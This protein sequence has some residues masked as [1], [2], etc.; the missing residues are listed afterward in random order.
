MTTAIDFSAVKAKQQKT[1]SSGDY[2]AVAARI[3]PISEQLI[4][5]AD[6]PA[7]AHVLDIAAGSG[8]AAIAAARCGCVVT[9]IDYV[10]ELLDRGRA[11]AA[12]EGLA[13]DFEDGDAEQL[14][15]PDSSF[16]AVVSVVGVMFA[17]DQERAA[18]ELLRVCRPGGTVALASWT[19]EGFVGELFRT[20]GRHVPPP[21]GLRPPLEW[22]REER[23]LELLGSGVGNVRMQRRHF[24][25][26]FT[27]PEEFADFFRATYGPTLK[28]FEALDEDGRHRLYGDLV[29]L[30]RWSN[31]SADDTVRIPAEYLEVIAVRTAD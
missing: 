2:A 13:V 24:V 18:A 23:I 27:A 20:M 15:Y 1:W 6:L 12:A 11:R 28:A 21:P 19:P 14:A 3:H 25:F 5:T 29:D 31:R 4:Q 16:D 30:A 8:N 9:G 26:R 7:G 22:G 17:P 10:P